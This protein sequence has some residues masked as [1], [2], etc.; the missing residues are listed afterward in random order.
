MLMS[1]IV[2]NCPQSAA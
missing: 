1:K 2:Q